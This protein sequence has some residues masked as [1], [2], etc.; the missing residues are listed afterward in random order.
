MPKPNVE[1]FLDLVQRSGLVEKDRLQGIVARLEQE[2]GG[3]LPDDV[4]E[5]A[6]RFVADKLITQWQCEKLLEGRHKGFFLGR[7]K[8]LGQLGQGGM[9]MVYLG[10]HVLMQRLVAIKVLPKNRVTDT[11]YL[12]RFHREARAAASLD[13][14]NIV[15]AY[16]VDND[17]D[18]HYLVMEFVDGRDLQQTVKKNGRLDYPLAADYIRQAAEGL[19]H[20]HANGLI[21]RDV[22]PAN[23]LVDQKNVVKVLDLG[24]AR[25][26][27]DD[28]A[29]LTVQY[30]ENVLGTADY[31]APEQAVDSHGADARADI[32][33]LGCALYFLLT[34]H[35]PFPDGTLPQRLM[36]HQKQMPPSIAKERPDA[37]ADLLAIC[38]KMMAKKP[39]ERYS[40]MNEVSQALRR[41]L[42]DRGFGSSF[43]SAASAGGS[44]SSSGRFDLSGV[45]RSGDSATPVA[46]R[47]TQAVTPVKRRDAE[48]LPRAVAE[49]AVTEIALTDTMANGDRSTTPLIARRNSDG[50]GLSDSKLRDKILRKAKPLDDSGPS[51]TPDARSIVS[52]DDVLGNDALAKRSPG[53]SGEARTIARRKPKEGPSKWV[54]I[55][56]GAVMFVGTILIIL[57]AVMSS[58]EGS[59]PKASGGSASKASAEA[60]AEPGAARP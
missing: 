22:K 38:M 55:G 14:P 32:Y 34:G 35:P 26:T 42:V 23:L 2:S 17:G 12:A 24:L 8:L 60:A 11:S 19:G 39:A 41:W 5:V 53:K 3:K 9:S 47:L 1:S 7:Y 40:S 48:E 20:A 15:R 10:E 36:A 21:H 27:D 44:P 58:R 45:G 43:V 16:D 28:R 25:F 54:W 33:S 6:R 13:H 30:D 31:L 29:S 18:T 57:A 50:A 59:Q 51:S 4:D 56:I 49:V 37:P 52:L 46:R